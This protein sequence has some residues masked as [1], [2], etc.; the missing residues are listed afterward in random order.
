MKKLLL[1]TS[2]VILSLVGCGDGPKGDK[3]DTIVVSPSPVVPEE[4][5][6]IDAIVLDENT[7]RLGLGQTVLTS[8]LSCSLSTFTAGDR[9]QASIV[10]H[11]TLSGLSQ[12]ATFLLKSEFNQPDA[13]IT[14]GVSALP[15]PFKSIYLTKYLL[16]CQGQVVIIQTGYH[17]FDLLSDDASVLYIDGAKIIDND[18]AH[19]STLVSAQKYLRKGVHTF[20]LDYAEIGAGNMSLRLNHNG[21]LLQSNVFFH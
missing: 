6:E 17:S 4:Q 20:R 18:L 8:G 2:I 5:A 14:S 13:P 1:L 9:I 11:N 3:G 7:Y 16:R 21:T 10:G 12:V 15:E 19:G